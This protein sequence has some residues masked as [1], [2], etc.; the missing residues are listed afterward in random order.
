VTE[1]DSEPYLEYLQ[2]LLKQEKLPSVITTSYGESEQ[3]VPLSYRH[4]VCD[5]LG[6]LGARGVSVIFS[7]GDSGPGW[8][9]L[10]NDGNNTPKF[11]PQFPAA[12]P[13]VTSVG[14]THYEPEEAVYFSSG[15]F[16]ETWAAPAYQKSALNKFFKNHPDSWKQWK[17]YFNTT[18]RGFPD[19]AGQASNYEVVLNGVT[20]LIGGTSASSPMFA[21][22]VALVNDYRAKTGKK[23]LGF[24]NPLLYSR[25]D[26]FTDI[27][28][29]KS[30]GCDGTT[31]G[32]PIA[33]NPAI[34]P[35]AGWNATT[36]WVSSSVITIT[37]AL[38]DIRFLQDP[39]TG[40]GTP[41]FA[42]LKT[43]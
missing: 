11:L 13:W 25:P 39:V 4:T 19:V 10:S 32:S 26:A 3:T 17:K 24:L 20:G 29:G 35:G 22:I 33:G 6:R 23:P 28:K 5:L 15:G 21:G 37:R 34:I 27:T 42:I 8:S 16:S 18:G 14:G 30:E 38:A 43:I 2:Y 40:L 36:G 7:A 1:N 41:K 31:W 12:C 9:C